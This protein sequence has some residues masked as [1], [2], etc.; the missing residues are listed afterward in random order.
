MNSSE[1]CLQNLAERPVLHFKNDEA[2]LIAKEDKVGLPSFDIGQV[3]N[4]VLLIRLRH[5]LKKPVEFLFAH[6]ALDSSIS[7]GIIV[8]M[9]AP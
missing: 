7:G 4:G 1:G 8:A 5:R 6:P 3:P 2:Y 9:A